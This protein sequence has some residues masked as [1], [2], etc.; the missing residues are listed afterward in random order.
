MIHFGTSGRE[1]YAQAAQ[2]VGGFIC[3]S[4]AALGDQALN[5]KSV[6]AISNCEC[7]GDGIEHGA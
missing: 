4:H 7:R 1:R 3:L 6:C 5:P 2:F